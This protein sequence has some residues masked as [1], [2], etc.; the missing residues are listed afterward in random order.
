MHTH[1]ISVA[2]EGGG[3]VRTIYALHFKH[4]SNIIDDKSIYR[5]EMKKTDKMGAKVRPSDS[6]PAVDL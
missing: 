5:L 2:S 1:T 4:S 6:I 3:P